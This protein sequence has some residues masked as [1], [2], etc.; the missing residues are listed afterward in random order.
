MQKISQRSIMAA[1][2]YSAFLKRKKIFHKPLVFYSAL[3]LPFTPHLSNDPSS[4]VGL[5]VAS[6]PAVVGH[7]GV[8]IVRARVDAVVELQAFARHFVS[9]SPMRSQLLGTF[10]P[11]GRNR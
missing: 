8:P 11:P 6:P 5:L 9:G 2:K 3:Y 10:V 4:K 7:S 1:V